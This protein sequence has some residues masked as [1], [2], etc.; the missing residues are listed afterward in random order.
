MPMDPLDVITNTEKIVPYYQAIFSADEQKV[1]GYEILGRIHMEGEYK[2]LGFFFH[3]DSIPEEY[4]MEVDDTVVKKA[5]EEMKEL[6]DD[7]FIF[8]NRDP[9]LLMIDHGESFLNLLLEEKE[10]G[11]DL[12]RIVL[13][14]TEHNYLGDIE[15]LHHL[16]TYYRTYGIKIAIDNIGKESSNL[17]RIGLLSPDILKIDLQPL[18]LASPSQSYFDVL[19]SISLLARK[20]G[21]TLLYEDIEA[22][23]Q[24]Q[25]AWKNGGRY[26]QGYYLHYPEREFIDRCVLKER[27]QQEFNHFIQFEKKKLETLYSYSDQFHQR[28]SQLVNK[29]KKAVS[30]FDELIT[31][32]AEE[33]G[34][35]SFRIYI[36]DE[37]G[38]QKSGNIF[39]KEDRWI[40]QKEYYMKNWSWRPYF[41]ENIIRMR[42]NKKGF[43]S[44][45]YSDIETGET[46]RTFS[47]PLDDDHYLF[48]DIPYSYLY[49]QDGLL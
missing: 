30:Q 4:R 23:F 27:L 26:Y 32:L 40:F 6:D 41:L 42:V 28:V 29:Y 35:M 46:I 5:L 9:N 43:L 47:Y 13:E 25:Y 48:I 14:I 20:I 45:L 39:R 21:A 22:N 38:F 34:D 17:D 16:L 7:L 19:F 31:H 37:N 12:N 18:K 49:E 11:L 10:K 3:D 24:L 36:C 2:S 15:Q 8:I 33:L 1:I 44:D